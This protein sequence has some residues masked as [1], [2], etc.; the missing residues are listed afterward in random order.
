MPS[1]KI[2][3]FRPPVY[4]VSTSLVYPKTSFTIALPLKKS[5]A[6]LVGKILREP[7]PKCIILA[8]SCSNEAEKVEDF[9]E[10][11]IISSVELNEEKVRFVGEYRARIK[12]LY[13]DKSG[14]VWRVS[15]EAIEDKEQDID[16][17][18]LFGGL[19]AIYDLLSR[20]LR[21]IPEESPEFIESFTYIKEHISLRE[22]ESALNLPWIALAFMRHIDNK[23][24]LEVLLSDNP[25]DRLQ[26]II[27][28]LQGEID[29]FCA[30]EGLKTNSKDIEK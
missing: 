28:I 19:Q 18:L 3:E 20:L 9:Q 6:D 30:A 25:V 24:K 17:S 23:T 4:T 29:I 1:N 2:V 7:M 22:M 5:T 21:V 15:V 12:N 8:K 14:Q 10:V 16:K 13:F 27:E 26:S 11:G